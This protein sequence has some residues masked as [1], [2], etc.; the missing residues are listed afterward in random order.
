MLLSEWWF[1]LGCFLVAGSLAF[2]L[3]E[4]YASFIKRG[5]AVARTIL[6]GAIIAPA[7]GW[8]GV[9]LLDLSLRRLGWSLGSYVVAWLLSC[10][11]ACAGIMLASMLGARYFRRNTTAANKPLR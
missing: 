5:K 6:N 1:V 9:L 7:V 10:G 11:I 4:L 3:F 2:F 8:Y